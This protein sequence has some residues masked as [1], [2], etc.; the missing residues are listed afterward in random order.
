MENRVEKVLLKTKIRNFV[1][2]AMN[3]INKPKTHR[4]KKRYSRKD[5]SWRKDV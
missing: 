5:K 1:A 3:K 4:N 2:K